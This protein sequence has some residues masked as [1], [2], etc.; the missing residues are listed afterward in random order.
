[1]LREH[2]AGV[3]LAAVSGGA[4]STALLAALTAVRDRGAEGAF[5]LRCIHV[6]HGIRPAAESR[7][8]ADF[9][10]SLCEQFNIPCRIVSIPPGKIAAV[11][12]ANGLGIEAAARLY[13]RRAW[14]REARR[15]EANG[16]VPVRIVTAHTADDALETALMRIFRGAGPAGLAAMPV[17]SGRLLRPLLALGRVNVIAYLNAKNIPWREDS[18]NADIRFFRNRI[19]RRLVPLLNESFPCWKSGLAALAETQSLAAACIQDQARR[20]PWTAA[21]FGLAANAEA[22]FAQSA[23]VRE[24]SL[25]QGIDRLL[26]GFG[27]VPVKRSTVRRFC[28]GQVKAADLGPL[29]VR[30][31]G[32]EVLL[33]KK[34]ESA[35][36][37]FSL[38]IKEP[39]FYNLKRV[40]ITVKPYGSG[41]ENVAEGFAA[42]LPMVLRQSFSGEYIV[43]SG[44]KTRARNLGTDG[45]SVLSA[46]D[47]L[48]T[49]AFIGS[50][51]LIHG[52]G[53]PAQKPPLP[54]QECFCVVTVQARSRNRGAD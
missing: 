18:T 16:G 5:D 21:R 24:E 32:G 40:R 48:G 11:A 37:G 9:V 26:A 41:E 14:F 10:R 42:L 51:G 46:V 12:Q 54:E 52:R 1:M 8:D 25:F 45:G 47:R 33:M 35:E 22:F 43:K 13:R 28:E 36:Y 44:R 6:E 39:G 27:N 30:L 19:R 53:I 20:I 34:P 4:D 29:W 2:G 15:I 49:A 7:G 31:A 17:K 38:L 3:Y 23:I 50:G